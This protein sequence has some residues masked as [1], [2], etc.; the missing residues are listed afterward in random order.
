MKVPDRTPE[1]HEPTVT[2]TLQPLC[3][4]LERDPVQRRQR[5]DVAEISDSCPHLRNCRMHFRLGRFPQREDVEFQPLPLQLENLIENQGL[6]ELLKSLQ[7]I[8]DVHPPG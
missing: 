5:S 6:G 3:I 1:K 7:H 2:R 8:R 4:S